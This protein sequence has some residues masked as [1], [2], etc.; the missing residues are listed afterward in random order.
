MFVVLHV[1]AETLIRQTPTRHTKAGGAWALQ[2]PAWPVADMSCSG[3]F[4][5]PTHLHCL[6]VGSPILRLRVVVHS[7]K[8]R[9]GF[10]AR[11]AY[12]GMAPVEGDHVA[13]P[14]ASTADGCNLCSSGAGGW[15]Q[16]VRHRA[17][18]QHGCAL[19]SHCLSSA[20]GAH[21]SARPRSEQRLFR[22]AAHACSSG[23]HRASVER[24]RVV[25]L[26]TD[27]QRARFVWIGLSRQPRSVGAPCRGG[28]RLDTWRRRLAQGTPPAVAGCGV[29]DPIPRRPCLSVSLW[30]G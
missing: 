27:I 30:H 4:P 10:A 7:N 3:H 18:S 1:G 13:A 26:P 8:L 16:D 15:R 25:G 12:A 23:G 6:V 9:G 17:Q 21:R 20:S 5:P 14:L 11:F 19:A 28:G 24:A 2:S 22:G 29:R